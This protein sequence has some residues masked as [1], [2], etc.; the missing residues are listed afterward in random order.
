[1][2]GMVTC[3]PIFV[4]FVHTSSSVYRCS[5][6]KALCD[7]DNFPVTDSEAQLELRQSTL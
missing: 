6:Q 3:Y 1:M 2:E 5:P 7:A 4:C